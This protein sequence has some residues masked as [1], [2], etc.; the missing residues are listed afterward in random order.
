MFNGSTSKWLDLHSKAEGL[1]LLAAKLLVF[2][3]LSPV[4]ALLIPGGLWNIDA[5]T[6]HIGG[7]QHFGH[8]LAELLHHMIPPGFETSA[9]FAQKK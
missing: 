2:F 1:E 3:W 9:S 5:T 6:D 8:T 7:D 4:T